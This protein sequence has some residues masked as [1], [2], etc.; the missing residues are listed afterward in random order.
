MRKKGEYFFLG[1][2]P[3]ELH[4]FDSRLILIKLL[5]YVNYEIRHS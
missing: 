4:K 1:I 5:R 3:R 2:E